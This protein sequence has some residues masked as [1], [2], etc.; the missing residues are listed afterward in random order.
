MPTPR[1]FSL[2]GEARASGRASEAAL[3]A[4]FGDEVAVAAGRTLRGSPTSRG[5]SAFDDDATTVWQT[6]FDA[7]VG[8]AVTIEHAE[9]LEADTLRL[10]WLDDGLHSIPTEITVTDDNFDVITLPVPATA[11]VDGR[12][13]VELAI[14]GYRS[15]F[16]T[17][18]VSG[19]DQRTTPEYFSRL[20]KVLPLGIS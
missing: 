9:A 20:P 2:D 11:P 7:V 1:S 14:P 12:A 3:T 5:A 6:P 17:I 16:S 8:A 15:N 10:T 19:V 4:L 18:T 13:S